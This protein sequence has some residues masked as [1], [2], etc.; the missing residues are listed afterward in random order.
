MQKEENINFLTC[1][2][3]TPFSIILPNLYI[4]DMHFAQN[5]EIISALSI[6][7]VINLAPDV[8]KN[9]FE[10]EPNF[11]YLTL[12]I[13]DN[14][15]TDIAKYFAV[16]RNFIDKYINSRGVL[17]HCAAGISR[18]ATIIIA[19]VMKTLHLSFQSAFSFVQDRHPIADPNLNFLLQLMQYDEK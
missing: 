2:S 17:V 12:Y 1:K 14:S 5:K 7:A 15:T 8:A 3:K 4:S 10:L 18:S 13:Q 11:A 9:A 6:S 19:Y 16:T